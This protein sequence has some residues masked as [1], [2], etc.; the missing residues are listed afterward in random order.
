MPDVYGAVIWDE[1]GQISE[2]AI[3]EPMRITADILA[4][5]SVCFCSYIGVHLYINGMGTDHM[6]TNII[7]KGC[8]FI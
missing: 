6:I 8:E 1:N 4:A 7:T 3:A 2:N 5:E